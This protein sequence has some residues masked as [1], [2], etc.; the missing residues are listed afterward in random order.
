MSPLEED[1]RAALGR[2]YDP[3]SVVAQSP[4]SIIDMGLLVDLN[5]TPEGD[6]TVVIRPTSAMC[7]LI[8]S[9][10][11]AVDEAVAA[12]P[13]V[14]S[15]TTRIDN[16]GRWSEEVMTEAGRAALA[17]RRERSRR[18]VPVKFREWETRPRRTP[19]PAATPGP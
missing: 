5:T 17:A 6:V 16:S 4:L 1:V 12:V 2:V 15:V 11:Q 13:G 18:E 3:C 19:A 7:T 14:A 8:A 10:M 9:I